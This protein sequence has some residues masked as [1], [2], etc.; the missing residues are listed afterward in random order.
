MKK[1]LALLLVLM[2]ALP[3]LALG[4]NYAGTITIGIFEPAS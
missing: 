1:T 2:L 4:E 3:I